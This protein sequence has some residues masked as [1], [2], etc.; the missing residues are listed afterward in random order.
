MYCDAAAA[1]AAMMLY[2]VISIVTACVSRRR[3]YLI[4]CRL[5]VISISVFAVQFSSVRIFITRN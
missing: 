2:C 5:C 3:L 4:A 1:A